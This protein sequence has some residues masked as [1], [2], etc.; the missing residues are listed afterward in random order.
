MTM[1]DMPTVLPSVAEIELKDG[2]FDL[3]A[4]VIASGLGLAAE[5][6]PVLLRAGEITSR[7]EKG[8][9]DDAGWYRLTFFH[10]N[11]RL[12]LFVDDRGHIARRGLIDFGS[13]P[14]PP[15]ARRPGTDLIPGASGM[16]APRAESSY[17]ERERVEA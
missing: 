9:D 7:C 8:L 15:A 10:G 5:T 11:R 14:V 4:D 2:T 13:R 6:V 1:P 3:A 16:L 17:P 12:R